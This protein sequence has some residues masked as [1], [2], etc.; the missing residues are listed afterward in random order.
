M[1][2][3]TNRFAFV[4]HPLDLSYIY[5]HPRFGWTKYLPGRI[6]EEIGAWLPPLYLGQITGGESPITGQK[7]LGFLYTLGAT[8]RQIKRHGERFINQRLLMAAK[9]AQQHGARLMGLGAYTSIVGDAGKTLAAQ[10]NIAITTGNS[11]TVAV[12]IETARTALQR[13]GIHEM[14]NVQAMV[15]GATGS[16]GSACARMLAKEV[17]AVILASTDSVKLDI[18]QRRIELETPGVQV[19]S[20]VD[21]NALSGECDLIITATSATGGRILDITKCHSGAVIYDVARPPDVSRQ[22]A[23]LRP[24]VLVVEGGEVVFPG[25]IN[26]GYDFRLPVNTA[27]ACLAETALLAMEGRFESFTIGRDLSLARIHEIHELFHKH[28]FHIAP[29]RSFGAPLSDTDF[30]YA[31]TFNTRLM[32]ESSRGQ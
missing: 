1:D 27:F 3:S 2:T 18:L 11:L 25:N 6:V 23:E 29:I 24:D 4:V 28:K 13:L 26:F 22:E 19:L 10:T 14:R 21:A 32:H 20:T 7:I 30:D 15:V 12:T 8:P 5:R 17:Y 16:I 31:R 9:M